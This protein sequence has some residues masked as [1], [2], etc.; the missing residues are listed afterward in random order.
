MLGNAI[1]GFLT[2]RIGSV[3]TLALLAVAQAVLLTAFALTPISPPLFAV[4]VVLWSLF[5][6]SFMAP[7]QARLVALAPQATSLVL[8][9]NAAA[10]YL[11]IS[12]GSPIASLVLANFGLA[13]L[14]IS[15][16]LLALLAVGHLAISARV[17]GD[18]R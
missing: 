10:I 9:L 2:D 14:G 15:G 6:W 1:G 18:F 13:G 7:Q 8:G 17:S 3:R 4:L 5:G 11:G 12:I 16:G